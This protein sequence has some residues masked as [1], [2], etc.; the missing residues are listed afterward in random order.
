MV[1]DYFRERSRSV[2]II[3][4]VYLYKRSLSTRALKRNFGLA[5]RKLSVLRP[6]P[7]SAMTRAATAV[8]SIIYRAPC[9]PSANRHPDQRLEAAQPFTDE[10]LTENC[11]V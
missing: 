5:R 8:Q 11:G 7:Y 1:K 4:N 9:P 3:V 10:T 2:P 6:A